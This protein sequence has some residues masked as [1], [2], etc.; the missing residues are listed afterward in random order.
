[1]AIDPT[2]RIA[3]GA[4][5]AD[6]AEVG[7][8][9]LIGAQV[10]LQS[11]VRLI[12]HVNVAGLTTI[13]E[14]TVVYPFAS[15]GTPPQSTH[16]RGGATRLTIGSRCEIRE[17]VTINTGTED[18]GGITRIGERCLFMVGSHVGHD[19]L[20]GN[21]VTFANNVVLG[22]HVTVGD[23]TFF[24]GHVA[25]HQFV[26][27]GEGVMVSG[28][29][30][31]AD[32]VIPFGFAIGRIADLAGLNVVGLRRRG[33]TRSHLQQ[34]RQAYQALFHG[35]GVFAD[36]V[37]AVAKEYAAD[38]HVQKIITFIRATG[39]RALMRPNARAKR[40]NQADAS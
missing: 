25:V 2:A 7:P 12:G 22:G 8:Y 36:R 15:L 29:S 20:I 16:Y 19:C 27:V 14:G 18:G 32:D 24:G 37:E 5:I 23:N 30:G 3:D 33:L 13:G 21:E 26:R 34:L 38:P 10:E 11:G 35:A 31:I 1:M 39:K 4:R 28:M 9:C 6:D 40:E 17:H